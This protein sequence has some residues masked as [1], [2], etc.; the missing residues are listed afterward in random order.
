MGCLTGG[1]DGTEFGLRGALN[2][3]QA[4]TDLLKPFAERLSA[5]GPAL[6]LGLP[7]CASYGDTDL[8]R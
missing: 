1:L 6:F 8:R 3:A 2:V 4:E 5:V 7:L